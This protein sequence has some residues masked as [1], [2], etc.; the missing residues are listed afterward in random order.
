MGLIFHKKS[1]LNET[2]KDRHTKGALARTF[3]L[4]FKVFQQCR[5][6]CRFTAFVA[7]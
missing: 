2:S 5:Y 1:E 7:C 3:C 6:C 4:F